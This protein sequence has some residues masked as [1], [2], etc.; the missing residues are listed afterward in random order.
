MKAAMLPSG[1]SLSAM[2]LAG[3]LLLSA[4]SGGSSPPLG[5]YI[6]DTDRCGGLKTLTLGNDHTYRLSGGFVDAVPFPSYVISGTWTST[7]DRITFSE[8]PGG[9]CT[10]QRGLYRWRFYGQ[11]LPFTRVDDGC[12]RRVVEGLLLGAW[13]VQ[14]K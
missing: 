8:A 10:G 14:E 3:G 2:L 5:A 1:K 7:A 4:C 9:E 13:T 12:G 11:T 6:T